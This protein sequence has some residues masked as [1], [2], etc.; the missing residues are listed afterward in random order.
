MGP[1]ERR[2]RRAVNP[3]STR[4][5]GWWL[6]TRRRLVPHRPVASPAGPTAH[7]PR[8]FIGV[9]SPGHWVAPTGQ[10]P[11]WDWLP[12]HGASPNL[13]AMPRWVRVWFRTPFIDRYAH[14]W[15]WW[16]GGWAVLVPGD[17]PPRPPDDGVREP[18]RPLPVGR[19]GAAQAET[20]PAASL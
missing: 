10:R 14:E 1:L 13:R 4:L 3:V 8:A 6:G 11:G 18:L 2:L 15:M 12:E 17:P 9:P 7:R 5:T 20:E 16:H 19:S